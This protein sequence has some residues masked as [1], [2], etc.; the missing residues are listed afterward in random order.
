[1]KLDVFITVK[2]RPGAFA[3]KPATLKVR[4][5]WRRALPSCPCQ[6][7]PGSRKHFSDGEFVQHLKYEG[8]YEAPIGS[9]TSGPM[10]GSHLSCTAFGLFYVA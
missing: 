10:L 6:I 9:M 8:K 1:M 5:C 4:L 7:Y 2:W 3:A